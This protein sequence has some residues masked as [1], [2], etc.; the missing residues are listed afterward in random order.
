MAAPSIAEAGSRASARAFLGDEAVIPGYWELGTSVAFAKPMGV[1]SASALTLPA[2]V[3]LG[4]EGRLSLGESLDLSAGVALP[5]KQSAVNDDPP[6]FAGFVLGRLALASRMSL[7]AHVAAER[8][9]HVYGVRDD[10]AWGATSGGW[11][12]RAF[13]DKHQRW[14]AFSWNLGLGGGRAFGAGEPSPA[15]LTEA[16]AGIGLNALAFDRHDGE[17]IGIAIGS[18]FAFPLFRGGSA[19]WAPGSPDINPQTRVNLYATLY[20]TLATGWN[21]TFKAAYLDRGNAQNPETILPVLT[22]G[23]DQRQFLVGF[24]YSEVRVRSTVLSR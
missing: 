15:W 11:D 4:L 16:I 21:V 22:N 24:S 14:L 5:P 9:L 19:F 3:R 6:L 7:Y 10:G 20:M 1:P 18:D 12:G 8:L 2:T 17:G 23:Y 13:M